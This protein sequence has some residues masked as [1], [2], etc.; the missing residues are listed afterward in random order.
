MTKLT[1]L[2]TFVMLRNFV[3]IALLT[4]LSYAATA[5]NLTPSDA[6]SKI[7]FTIKN[8][9]ADVTGSLKGLKGTMKFDPKKLKSSFFDVTVDVN[10]INTNNT[11]RDNHLKQPDFFDAE[12]FPLIALKTTELLAKGNHQYTAKAALTMHG[13]SK[14]IQ[15]DF[16][17]TPVEAGYQFIGDFIV[18]RKDYGIGGNSM[19]MGDDVKVHLDVI[20][21]K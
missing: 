21:K 13:V 17:A 9:G 15:F 11:R 1:L 2:K 14:N 4:L 3:T 8:M 20:G 10:T 5:Q 12:K 18:N 19:T 7:S 16:T 6:D